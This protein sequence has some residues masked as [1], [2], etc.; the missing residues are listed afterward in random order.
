M[1]ILIISSSTSTSLEISVCFQYVQPSQRIFPSH[2]LFLKDVWF[3][4][5]I[6]T[7]CSPG[8]PHIYFPAVYL[9]HH[10]WDTFPLFCL[11]SS[12]LPDPTPSSI[13]AYFSLGK[14]AVL[15]LFSRKWYRMANLF[16]IYYIWNILILYHIWLILSLHIESWVGNYFPSNSV[17]DC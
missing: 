8:L 14:D 1:L 4:I 15:Q 16:H 7:D 13:L 17:L 3:P 6:R 2:F 5:P 9:I 10:H 12:L 11:E